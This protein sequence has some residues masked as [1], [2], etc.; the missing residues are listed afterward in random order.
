[1][2]SGIQLAF[3]TALYAVMDKIKGNSNREALSEA[4]EVIYFNDNSKYLGALWRITKLLD[5]EAWERLYENPRTAF[6][7]YV[8]EK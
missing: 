5:R 3:F 7:K 8:R 2:I 6:K 4:I 1:M